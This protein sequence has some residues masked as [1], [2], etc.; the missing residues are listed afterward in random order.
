MYWI[1]F[2]RLTLSL[3]LSLSTSSLTTIAMDQN[4]SE[5]YTKIFL[6]YFFQYQ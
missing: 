6:I 4:N 3:S 2:R 5:K 1:F